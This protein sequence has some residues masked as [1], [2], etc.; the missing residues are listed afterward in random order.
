MIKQLILTTLLVTN[1]LSARGS[2][3]EAEDVAIE[4]A[5]EQEQR[6][7]EEAKRQ[8]KYY[9]TYDE[10]DED[11][12]HTTT[13]SPR[14]IGPIHAMSGEHREQIFN[15]IIY[16]KTEA[17]CKVNRAK[18]LQFHIVDVDAKTVFTA[19]LIDCIVGC[20]NGVPVTSCIT[21]IIELGAAK[22]AATCEY[23]EARNLVSEAKSLYEKAEQLEL[24]LWTDNNAEDWM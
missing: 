11:G 15:E 24:L 1:S 7:R 19:I 3:Y 14:R 16:L 13:V 20:A 2:D 21:C 17:M 10:V 12:N 6:A 8:S 23:W 22:W 9:D 4:E 18:D 5:M